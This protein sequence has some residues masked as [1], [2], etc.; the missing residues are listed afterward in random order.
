MLLAAGSLAALRNALKQSSSKSEILIRRP[1]HER[2]HYFMVNARAY[3]LL[4]ELLV[5]AAGFVMLR[6]SF[7]RRGRLQPSV[8]QALSSDARPYGATDG[9][10]PLLSPS[11]Q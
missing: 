1:H 9:Q 7:W 3:T 6:L 4:V 11:L 10:S 2:G 8:G 5:V